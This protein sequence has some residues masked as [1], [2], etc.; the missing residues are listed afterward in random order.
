M[1]GNA[2]WKSVA[3]T[4]RN[5]LSVFSRNIESVPAAPGCK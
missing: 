4:P 1:A 3:W 5:D 2:F